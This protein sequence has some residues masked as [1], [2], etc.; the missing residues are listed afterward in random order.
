MMHSASVVLPE[1]EPPSTAAWRFSTSLLSVMLLLE[2]QRAAG[3]DAGGAVAGLI[4]QHG[5][6]QLL[7][8]RWRDRRPAAVVHPSAMAAA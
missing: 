2:R 1:P 7:L 8:L 5:E 4:E 6:R 3:Q